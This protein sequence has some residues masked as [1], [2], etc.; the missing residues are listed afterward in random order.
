MKRLNR[1]FLLDYKPS[2]PVML[3]KTHFF[4]LPIKVLQFGEGRFI[5][6]FLNYFIEIANHKQLFNG[7]TV[8]I[9]PR[10]ADK[11]SIINEQDGLFTLCACGLQDGVEKQEFIIISSIHKAIAAKT[12]W[13]ETLELAEIPSLEII[14]S[15]TTEAGLIYDPDDSIEKNPP[16]SF[17]GKLTALLYHR[18]KHFDGDL[19]RGL[20]I[21]PLELVENNG[22]VLKELVLKLVKKWNLEENFMKWLNRANAFYKSIVDR[23]V[24]GYPNKKE[25]EKYQQQLGYEDK[26]FNVAELYHSWII[27]ADEKLQSIIPFDKAGLNVQFVDNIATYFLRKVRIL[28]GAHTSMVPIAYLAG[29][30]FVKESIE[31]PLINI[32]IQN[33]LENEVIPF[34]NLPKNELIQYK[35]TILERFRNPFIQHRLLSISLYST[36]KMRL[37]VVPSILSYYK[38]FNEPPPLLSFAFAAF[39]VFMHIRE[40]EALNWFGYRD[41][42]KYQYH[43]DSNSLE[44]FYNAWNSIN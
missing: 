15:N 11:A 8:V 39:L 1:Q 12:Q 27:E 5:R 2:I 9:Q 33:I 23:I 24:T 17:P 38:K 25:L 36:S 40:K 21:L 31:D 35:D 43:D 42:E 13:K 29:K 18:Y 34:I 26:L 3:P 10:K 4:E 7:R 6:A 30:N 22:D 14:A 32:Y 19:N 28:N 20:V 44:F 16:D 37:R 41:S